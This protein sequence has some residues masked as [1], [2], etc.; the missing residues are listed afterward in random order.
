M[1]VPYIPGWRNRKSDAHSRRPLVPGP[2]DTAALREEVLDAGLTPDR[3]LQLARA[4]EDSGRFS[5]ALELLTTANRLR[6]DDIVERRLV[7]LRRRAFGCLDHSLPPP[8]WPPFVPEN[9]PGATPGPPIVTADDLTVGVLR[10]GILRHG[11]VL[12]RGLVSSSRVE[13]LRAIIDRAFDAYDRAQSD[14][15][16]PSVWFDPLDEVP[17][18]DETRRWARL[19]QGVLTGDSPRALYEFLETVYETGVDRLIA[20]YF[21]E[22]PAL[23]LEK[24]TLRRADPEAQEAMERN[25]WEQGYRAISLWHQDGAFLGSG[26]RSVNAWFALSRCGRD[27]PGMD[28]LPM[29]LNRLI[30][31]GEAGAGFGW[32]AAAETILREVPGVEVWRPEFEPGDVLFFDHLMMHR[33]ASSPSMRHVRYAIESWFFAP[34]VYPQGSTPLLV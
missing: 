6:R 21:S 5:E 32:T 12:V 30:P 3:A 26:I 25:A 1:K 24:C 9:A 33:T 13:R 23:S 28:L 19:G 20:A 29:R 27:A 16:A 15:A 31:T 22:R 4:S 7:R 17:K 2:H 34:S 8:D 14:G 10:N 18:G 11:S